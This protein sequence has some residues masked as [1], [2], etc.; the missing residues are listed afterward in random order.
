MDKNTV[1]ASEIFT[2][3]NRENLTQLYIERDL[4]AQRVRDARDLMMEKVVLYLKE[5]RGTVMTVNDIAETSGLPRS[6]VRDWLSN[7]GWTRGLRPT[8]VL[9]QRHFAEVDEDGNLIPGGK[10]TTTSWYATGYTC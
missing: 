4:A 10:K 1:K 8:K 6:T 9:V 7:R 2:A 5:H 3:E